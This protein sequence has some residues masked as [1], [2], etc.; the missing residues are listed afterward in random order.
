MGEGAGCPLGRLPR[1]RQA[2]HSSDHHLRTTSTVEGLLIAKPTTA[3]ITGHISTLVSG[4]NTRPES[5]DIT[6]I[7]GLLSFSHWV[8]YA[9]AF[10][11][12]ACPTAKG[13]V[14]HTEPIGPDTE[15]PE[16]FIVPQSV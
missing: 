12:F 16:A 8:A 3:E 14:Q 10:L 4:D 9:A 2:R 13:R 5:P 1:T 15:L 11:G 7:A 6:L